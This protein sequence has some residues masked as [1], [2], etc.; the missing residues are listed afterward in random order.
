MT[1]ALQALLILALTLALI[2]CFF[3]ALLYAVTKLLR[4]MDD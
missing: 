1:E 2:G 3:L 4:R